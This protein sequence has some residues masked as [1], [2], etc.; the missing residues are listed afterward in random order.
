MTGIYRKCYS[1][2]SSRDTR[3]KV[4]RKTVG[5]TLPP[6]LIEQAREE[7][8]N[9]S[10][11]SEQALIAVL[12][13]LHPSTCQKERFSLGTRFSFCKREGGLVLRP[14]FEPGSPARKAGILG[15]CICM[16]NLA[17]FGRRGSFSFLLPEPHSRAS[18][19]NS[20]CR[21]KFS[22]SRHAEKRKCCFSHKDSIM[23][24][25]LV[26]SQLLSLQHP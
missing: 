15:P 8:L 26:I 21:F 23:L 9:I 1:S 14:G 22:P 16:F 10:K 20:F 13:S 19:N 18:C 3:V 5:I 11:V 17:I 25:V 7:G 12:S 4:N 2:E 6:K 24:H